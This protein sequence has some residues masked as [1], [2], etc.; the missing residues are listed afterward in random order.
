M[1]DHA[2][3]QHAGYPQECEADGS[4]G[5]EEQQEGHPSAFVERPD[6]KRGH[7]V[8]NEYEQQADD[9]KDRGNCQGSFGCSHGKHYAA[10]VAD[11]SR[12]PLD[13]HSKPSDGPLRN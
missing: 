9:G 12:L 10:E 11:A 6:R 2:S 3:H 7:S 1:S 5:C 8:N 13:F 4:L